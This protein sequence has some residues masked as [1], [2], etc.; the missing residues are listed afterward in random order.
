VVRLIPLVSLVGLA[1]AGCA[2]DPPSGARAVPVSITAAPVATAATASASLEGRLLAEARSFVFRARNESCLAVGTAFAAQGAIITNRHVAAGAPAL[3]LSTWDGQDFASQV[4]GHDVNHDLARLDAV[5]PQD[6]YATL[7]PSDPAVGTPVYAAGYPLGDQLTVTTGR[8]LG[9]VSGGPLGVAG[10]VLQISDPIQH[11]NSGSPLLDAA[12]QV[13]GVVFAIDT[14][15][16]D[17]LAMPVSS[18]RD[19]LAGAAVDSSVLS[20][21]DL[22]P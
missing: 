10:S 2:A 22:S 11:G 5:P 17:G 15:S 14:T 3:D 12:G 21:A 4:A 8:V 9:R 13:V 16:H 7:A 6:D 18:L 1:A 20:C 19:L